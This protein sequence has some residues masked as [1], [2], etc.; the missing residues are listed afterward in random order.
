LRWA[1]RVLMRALSGPRLSAAESLTLSPSPLRLLSLSRNLPSRFHRPSHGADGR[2]HGLGE[3]DLMVLVKQRCWIG[4]QC[5]YRRYICGS[6]R[7]SRTIIPRG[8]CR[9]SFEHR[10][11]ASSGKLSTIAREKMGIACVVRF[12]F[13]PRRMKSRSCAACR[14]H[15]LSETLA[16]AELRAGAGRGDC[17]PPELDLPRAAARRP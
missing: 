1:V 6:T 5:S 4:V 9:Y 3:A 10:S 13:L 8:E 2:P 17:R 12:F 16:R 14:P 15:G 11:Q 7:R